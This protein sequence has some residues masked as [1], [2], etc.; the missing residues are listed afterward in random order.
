[1]KSTHALPNRVQS[2]DFFRGLYVLLAARIHI[3]IAP[4]VIL[5][6]LLSSHRRSARA[7][8]WNGLI[9]GSY[10]TFFMFLA[11]VSIP[12]AVANRVSKG[13]SKK[14]ILLHAF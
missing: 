9:S 7:P 3:C 10:S 1:M 5:I 8:R 13:D 2:V 12:Y 4:S 14:T 11:G 6:F